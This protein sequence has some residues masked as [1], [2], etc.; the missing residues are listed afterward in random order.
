MTTFEA[1]SSP[2]RHKETLWFDFPSG[3]SAE[4]LS[5]VSGRGYASE[6]RA[7]VTQVW[8]PPLGARACG[9]SVSRSGVGRCSQNTVGTLSSSTARLGHLPVASPSL[10]CERRDRNIALL[11]FKS[12][13]AQ[14]LMW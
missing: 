12:L 4:T 9:S 7:Y 8:A 11:V 14:S 3:V 2:T 10:S 5:P 6:G 13:Y 1:E